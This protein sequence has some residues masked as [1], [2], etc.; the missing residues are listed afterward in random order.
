MR[1][2]PFAHAQPCCKGQRANETRVAHGRRLIMKRRIQRIR[3]KELFFCFCCLL[4]LLFSGCSVYTSGQHETEPP[5]DYG[6]PPTLSGLTI[7]PNPGNPG[8]VVTLTVNYVDPDSDLSS[9]VAAISVD[10]EELS[11][12]VFRATYPSGVLTLPFTLSQYTRPSDRY[13]VLKIRDNSGNWS[14]AVSAI[15]SVR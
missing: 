4:A 5:A 7:S 6:T 15:L 10:G 8:M 3:V 9:G 11:S 2:S 12:L 13:V 14:N 1:T